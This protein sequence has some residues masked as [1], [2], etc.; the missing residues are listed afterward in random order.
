MK[1][2]TAKKLI[3]VLNSKK[4]IILPEDQLKDILNIKGIKIIR[5]ENTFISDQIR[6]LSLDS[7]IILQEITTNHELCLRK[8]KNINEANK[9]IDERLDTYEK[10]WDG[11]GCKVDYYH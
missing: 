5:N 2:M 7:I 11:C 3:N 8:L 4:V 9:L 1:D 10:M 6:I